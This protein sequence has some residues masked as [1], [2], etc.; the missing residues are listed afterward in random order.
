MATPVVVENDANL[1]G[2]TEKEVG[3][4]VPLTALTWSSMACIGGGQA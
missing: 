1:E 2:H 4:V 3:C